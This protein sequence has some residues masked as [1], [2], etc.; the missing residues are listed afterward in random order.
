MSSQDYGAIT[1]LSYDAYNNR[2][3]DRAASLVA[4]NLEFTVVASGET[5]R[6]PEGIRQLLQGWATA[7]PDSKVE[8]TNLFAADDRVCIE[9][10][11]RGTHTGL[12]RGPAGTIPPT[13]RRVEQRFCDVFTCKDGKIVAGNSY[14]DATNLM[15]QLGLMP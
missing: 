11:V 4:E 15:A 8:I 10:I 13:G 2:D 3:F 14:F 6:G 9:F 7:L 5:V 12:M 1:R